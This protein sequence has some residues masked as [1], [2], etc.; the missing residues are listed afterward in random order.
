[1]N[2]FNQHTLCRRAEGSIR[3]QYVLAPRRR[4]LAAFIQ[5]SIEKLTPMARDSTPYL[6]FSCPMSYRNKSFAKQ[7]SLQVVLWVIWMIVRHAMRAQAD[8]PFQ[9]RCV[10]EHRHRLVGCSG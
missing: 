8:V 4:G 3:W 7:Y 2:L 10:K 1:M 9:G 5:I 6:K